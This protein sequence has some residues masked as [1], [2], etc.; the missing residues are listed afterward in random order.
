ML[1]R[2]LNPLKR[3]VALPSLARLASGYSL[4][5]PFATKIEVRGLGLGV[6]FS[7]Q[8]E[9]RYSFKWECFR[10]L[11]SPVNLFPRP[12]HTPLSRRPLPLL[13]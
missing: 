7:I 5:A 10:L 8:A 6:L 13:I 4:N 9:L 2:A 3:K 1:S 12:T 11:T